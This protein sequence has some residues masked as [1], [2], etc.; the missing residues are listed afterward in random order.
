[1]K[2]TKKKLLLVISLTFIP[3][4]ILSFFS[5]KKIALTKYY[6]VVFDTSGG[7]PIEPITVEDGK[8]I[9]HELISNK[10]GFY[11]NYWMNGGHVWRMDKDVVTKDITLKASWE[12]ATYSITY[13]FDGGSYSGSYQTSYNMNS[14]FSLIRPSKDNAVFG[15]WFL[16][17]NKRIDEI[18][19]NSIFG[20]LTLKAAWITNLFI[21]STDE[22]KGQI[23]AYLNEE[24]KNIVT[25]TSSPVNNK[26]HL[27]KG[28][29]DETDTLL[30]TDQNIEVIL[31]DNVTTKIYSHYLSEEEEEVWNNEHGVNPIVKNE[32][33]EITYG[34]YPQANVNDETIVTKLEALKETKL[35]GYVYYAGEYYL[36]HETKLSSSFARE[37]PDYCRFDN[38][39][40][41]EDKKYYWFK[42]EPIKWRVLKNTEDGY[43]AISEKL[44]ETCRFNIVYDE[45]T[46]DGITYPANSYNSSYLRKWLN[47]EFLRKSFP[48]N[49]D[50]LTANEIDMS[51][52]T[53]SNP[54]HSLDF[55]DIFDKVY[56]F[57]YTDYQNPEYG[58]ANTYRNSSTRLVDTSDYNRTTGCAF[59]FE[60]GIHP[61]YYWTRSM[62]YSETNKIT[63]S[64][65][66]KA[67]V[68]NT[69]DVKDSTISN[70]PVVKIKLG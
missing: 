54:E 14:D 59:G 34:F 11:L 31:K 21:K 53:T 68:I 58:F 67:G 1:M 28:W 44:L 8:R 65:V 61:G 62:V 18:K 22:N 9:T 3:L 19:P 4:G 49:S 30:S 63:V 45:V 35:F 7:T 13:D 33:K 23:L 27:F 55:L 36:K 50:Y 5:I 17:T 56:A 2:Q 16:N 12:M 60:S 20:N 10:D 26:Y 25:L 70:Q 57:S 15:G 24:N 40:K 64:K 42:V 52:E 48:F 29:Y 47:G 46:I 43:L 32:G 38:N 66:N 6:T 39:T 51:S 37:V 69:T 41:I